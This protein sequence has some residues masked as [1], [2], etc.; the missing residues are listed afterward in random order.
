MTESILEEAQRLTTGDRNHDYGT[1]LDDFTR[2]IGMINALFAHK[3]K[4]PFV[5]EDWPLIMQ[6]CKCS[7]EVN[8]HKRDNAVDGAGYWNTLDMVHAERQRRG[9]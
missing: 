5:P 4:A 7:R 8:H 1:P 3:L 6:C 2:T 9:M